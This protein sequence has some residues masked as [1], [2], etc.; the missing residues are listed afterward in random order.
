MGRVICL[1]MVDDLAA[2]HPD[3]WKSMDDIKLALTSNGRGSVDPGETQLI[4]DRVSVQARRGHM[5]VN[6]RKCATMP[7]TASGSPRATEV[8]ANN[9]II[10]QVETL[11]LPHVTIQSNLK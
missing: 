10:S 1:A 11:K 5:M 3:G 4:M 9:T 7:V 6:T 8:T 2:D